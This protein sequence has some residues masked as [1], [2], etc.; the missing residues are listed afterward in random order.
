MHPKGGE[1]CPAAM[2]RLR[3]ALRLLVKVTGTDN[4][5]GVI[6][7]RAPAFVKGQ[8]LSAQRWQKGFLSFQPRDTAP[9]Q[10][11]RIPLLGLL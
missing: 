9:G 2:G 7:G 5:V 4:G 11:D 3:M 6:C 1:Q 8:E 10:G